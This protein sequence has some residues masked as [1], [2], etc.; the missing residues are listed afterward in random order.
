VVL[1][2]RIDT[3]AVWISIAGARTSLMVLAAGIF[4]INLLLKAL[5][6]HRLLRILSID[7]AP[8]TA[9]P[10]FL[11]SLFYG[12][13]TPGRVGEVMRGEILVRQ[14]YPLGVCAVAT[15]FDRVLDLISLIL[16]GLVL[17]LPWWTGHH[18]GPAAT[19]VILLIST[20][21]LALAATLLPGLGW[22]LVKR[23]FPRLT[24]FLGALRDLLRL[25]CLLE[26][27][28]WTAL[29][30]GFYF[31][32]VVA[33]ARALGLTASA[34]Q[35][36]SAMAAATV[37]GLIPITFQGLGTREAVLLLAL[38]EAGVEAEQAVSLGLAVFAVFFVTSV[39]LGLLGIRLRDEE[40]PS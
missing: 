10:E 7:L 37:V 2:W 28:G 13:V 29:A 20:L 9:L 23:F 3:R 30:A 18:F 39:S 35:L 33:V 8:R 16:I 5:R 19:A 36:I 26:L 31:G 15:L 22:P 6:W 1:L 17:G 25:P 4:A 21:G 11:A 14:G 24:P 12:S 40:S 27:V 32:T 38:A 34:G